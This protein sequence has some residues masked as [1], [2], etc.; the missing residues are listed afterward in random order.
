MIEKSDNSLRIIL[1]D[2][3]NLFDFSYSLHVLHEYD[4]ML[5]GVLQQEFLEIGGAGGQDDFMALEHLV[6]AGQ[7][8]VD[9]VLA[10]EQLREGILDRKSVV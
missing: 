3:E 2:E 9:E 7:R 4:G 10:G 8:D 1:F 6:L 5:A